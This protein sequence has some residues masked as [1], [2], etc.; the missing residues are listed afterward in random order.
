M[1]SGR[2]GSIAAR[3]R[4]WHCSED[5]YKELRRRSFVFVQECSREDGAGDR[6]I[7]K[8]MCPFPR[9]YGV[10]C[11]SALVALLWLSRVS[12]SPAPHF[13]V[14]NRETGPQKA[15]EMEQR[16][17]RILLIQEPRIQLVEMHGRCLARRVREHS[18]PPK[19]PFEGN[20]KF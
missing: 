20:F 18:T 19:A 12:A 5:G 13:S 1:T 15:T 4:V 14:S 10:R 9:E 16:P 11:N 3:Q 8:R 7:I 2:T 17:G 6:G